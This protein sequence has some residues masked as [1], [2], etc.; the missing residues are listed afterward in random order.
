MTEKENKQTRTFGN[1]ENEIPVQNG[2]E[3]Q[4]ES[5]VCTKIIELLGMILIVSTQSVKFK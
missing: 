1:L 2:D 4:D 3:I 5:I